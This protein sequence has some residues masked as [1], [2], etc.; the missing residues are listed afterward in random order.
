VPTGI[1]DLLSLLFMLPPRWCP[2]L[3]WKRAP[4]WLPAWRWVRRSAGALRDGRLDGISPKWLAPIITDPGTRLLPYLIH[5]VPDIGQ[6][7][8]LRLLSTGDE[9]VRMIAA[10]HI[11]EASFQKEEYVFLADALLKDGAPYRRL[12]ADVA[13]QSI[14]HGEFR[15]RAEQQIATF[16]DDPDK[17]V[18]AEAA[19]V[20]R[21][22][23]GEDLERHYA[24]ASRYPLRA[25]PSKS[26]APS[27]SFTCWSRRPAI[28]I[29]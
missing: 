8:L 26:E 2:K 19:N 27:L 20:F 7:L 6:R 5:W 21:S 3:L 16:F 9:T 28:S 4:A 17:E 24:L 13:S 11:F 12:A 14:K 23:D 22:I 18:R 1:A 25:K 10:W 29:P 15:H